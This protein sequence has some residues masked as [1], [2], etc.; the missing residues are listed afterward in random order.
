MNTQVRIIILLFAFFPFSSFG[1][2]GINVPG[3]PPLPDNSAELEIYSKN[4]GLLIPRLTTTE[5]NNMG[6]SGA[7]DQ[8]LLIYNTDQ[9]QFYYYD[10]TAWKAIGGT[11]IEATD[12]DGDT[13]IIVE[14]T[15]D[16]DKIHISAGGSEVIEVTSTG[17]A[18]KTGDIK[19][20]NGG[21]IVFDNQYALPTSDGNAGDVLSINNSGEVAWRNPAAAL[22]LVVGIETSS[23]ANVTATHNISQ[24][25]FY[26]RVM[27]WSNI[28]VTQMSFFLHQSATDIQ[29]EIGIYDVNLDLL[30]SGVSEVLTGAQTSQI[31]TIK[32]DSPIE[33]IAGEI[34]WFAL[35]DRLNG[36]MSAYRYTAAS[37]SEY[38]VRYQN[39]QTQFPVSASFS[40]NTEKAFWMAAY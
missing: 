40:G 3:D 2:T 13:K 22:G 34:Y 30:G 19:T 17:V 11:C 29:P 27:P 26:V 23:F 9:N 15:T 35:M 1:Q 39:S 31:V 12:E 4:K 14:Q 10:G 21:T 37:G 33:L 38:S 36:Q 24:T 28:R 18:H 6:A 20:V 32:L 7:A 5:M 8:G 16:E 25:I